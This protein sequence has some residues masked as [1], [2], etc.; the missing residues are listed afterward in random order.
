VIGAGV[1]AGPLFL[2]PQR[3]H[4]GRTA[5]RANNP[6]KTLDKF[7]RIGHYLLPKRSRE[8][9]ETIPCEGASGGCG[10]ARIRRTLQ[11]LR[12]RGWIVKN[13]LSL[14]LF[15]ASLVAAVAPESAD[16]FHSG[17]VGDCEGCHVMHSYPGSGA[18]AAGP[19]LLKGSDAS[20]TCLNCHQHQ[21]DAGP[22][23]F[24]ISTPDAEVLQIGA[25]PKQL[26]PGG[27]FA[28]LKK[29]YSWVSSAGA[30][31]STS[32]GDHHGHNLVAIDYNY[33]S[34]SRNA[35]APGGTYP[36]DKF[37]CI[38]C[39]DPHGKYRRNW[40]GSVTTAGIPI[41]N[42]GSYNSSRAPSS[43]GSVGSY[44][45]LG[46]MGYYPRD[47]NG[48]FAFSSNPPVAVAPASY[49]R[50]EATSVTRVAYGSGMSEWCK[51]CHPNIHAGSDSFTH[52]VPYAL[53]STISSYYNSYIKYG[54]TTGLESTAYWSTAPFEVG[55]SNYSTLLGIVS[56]TPGKGPDSGDGTPQVMCLSCHRAHASGWDSATRWN[57]KSDY[58]VYSGHYAQ[59]GQV[60]QPYGQ[61]RSEAEGLQAYYQIP[62]SRYNANEPT[63]CYKCHS[64]LPPTP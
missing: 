60:Y 51:N 15:A 63:F 36:S 27:D 39:H 2:S 23:S 30:A 44:R 11:A 62:E 19:A 20:S 56:N 31:V 59:E 18:P 10:F 17:G 28:W 52:P 3:N 61:G 40:D 38:S 22:T 7:S 1:F 32:N 33:Q 9:A 35:Q 14:L 29:T 64:T 53:G 45:L 41:A 13:W 21:G 47:V 12:R 8:S 5:W 57:T 16:A 25:P 37:S 42:S 49:N 50:T 26:T 24:H 54:T 55:T 48:S 6:A 43:K 58:V 4:P 34:D 46:G